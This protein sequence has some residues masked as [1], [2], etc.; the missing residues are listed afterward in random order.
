VTYLSV[1]FG[2]RFAGNTLH[3]RFALIAKP[4]FRTRHV[5]VIAL[6]IMLLQLARGHVAAQQLTASA[7]AATGEFVDHGTQRNG[8]HTC[9][10]DT[11]MVGIHV[12]NNLLICTDA[13]GGYQGAEFVDTGTQYLNIHACPEGTAMTG[14]HV[15][16]NYLSCAMIAPPAMVRVV[17]DSTQRDDMHACP[18]GVPMSGIHVGKNLLLCGSVN[19]T[20]SG[21]FV[22]VGTQRNGMHT[23]PANTFMVGN[24]VDKNLLLCTTDF[25]GYEADAEIADK[26]TQSF[27]MHA[28]PEGMAMTGIHVEKNLFSCAPVTT[29]T[30]RYVDMGTV[31]AGMHACD[32]NKPM[33]G[34]HVDNNWL[35][36][37]TTGDLQ[38]LDFHADPTLI[39]AGQ[40]STLSWTAQCTASNCAASISGGG[41]TLSNLALVGS[42]KVTPKANAEYTLTVSSDGGDASRKTSVDIGNT[43]TQT[44]VSKLSLINCNVEMHTI[45]IW[46]RDLTAGTDWSEVG[47]AP[48]RYD[49]SGACPG[50]SASGFSVPASGTFKDNHFYDVEAIDTQ[51]LACDGRDDPNESSC[52]RWYNLAPIAGSST[53]ATITETIS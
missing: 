32:Q 34:T 10:T 33:S 1:C 5:F 19:G 24:H 17:D 29:R 13:F 45:H 48:A 7:Q 25:G 28:C 30:S 47:A 42:A 26:S 15:D 41:Q 23:C 3:R 38:I 40:S 16:K 39:A 35:L 44:G 52:I 2:D 21:E 51:Q 18:A 36:C 6:A 20:P 37:G 14:I 9:P 12:D 49:S 50:A 46:M 11:F 8:M 22:D 53:G 31:R 4:R 27:G 43:P